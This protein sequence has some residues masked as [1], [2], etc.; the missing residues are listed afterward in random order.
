[1]LHA[2]EQQLKGILHLAVVERR[3]GRIAASLNCELEVH[4]RFLVEVR[5]ATRKAEA[6][7]SMQQRR[8]Q[9]V[10][11]TYTDRLQLMRVLPGGAYMLY[12]AADAHAVSPVQLHQ[13]IEGPLQ[14]MQHVE[15]ALK[16]EIA[17]EQR[18]VIQ[19]PA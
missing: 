17:A 14:Q 6:A 5:K 9:E 11:I 8:V 2:V 12:A 1:M 19:Q 16:A 4:G 7:F 10:L 13:A 3:S 18:A 15:A